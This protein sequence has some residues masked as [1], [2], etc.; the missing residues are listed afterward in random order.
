MASVDVLI[1]GGGVIG[2]AVARDL[3]RR[4]CTVLVLTRD[5]P[6]A[7][8]SATAAG[9]LEVHCPATM[10]PALAA[11]CMHSR[12]LYSAWAQELHAET[13]FDIALDTSGTLALA[14]SAEEL[15][16][17]STQAAVTPGSRLL[18]REVWLRL[19]PHLAP[20]LSGVLELPD[21]LHVNPRRLY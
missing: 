11:L 17:L 9:M 1:I 13:G 8:A 16:E 18:T 14:T 12:S 3:A 4:K 21:D 6:G 10:P 7:G 19:E 2:L 15:A 5:A 20:D